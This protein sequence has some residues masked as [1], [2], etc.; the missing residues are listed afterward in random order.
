MREITHLERHRRGAR[1][2][3]LH[4]AFAVGEGRAQRL[5]AADDLLEAALQ[6]RTIEGA[7]R[8]TAPERL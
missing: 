8:R 7:R 1:G 2:S 3:L 4:P 5:V 6:R